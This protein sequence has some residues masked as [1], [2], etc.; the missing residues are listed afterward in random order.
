VAPHK[1]SNA[2]PL[3]LSVDGD[4]KGDHKGEHKGEGLKAK[5]IKKQGSK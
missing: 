2:S 3:K 1:E 4:P 5:K